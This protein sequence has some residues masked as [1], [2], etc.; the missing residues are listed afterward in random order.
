[1][2]TLESKIDILLNDTPFF[3][4][5]EFSDWEV[6]S[7][8]LYLHVKEKGKNWKEIRRMLSVTRRRMK[9]KQVARRIRARNSANFCVLS[10]RFAE[11]QQKYN[12]LENRV[13]EYQTLGE[14]YK[15][16]QYHCIDLEYQIE[17]YEDYNRLV[18]KIFQPDS[19]L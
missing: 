4:N 12:D 1:M 13:A 5:M 8:E 9:N 3:L 2:S 16:L 19:P 18:A 17:A 7:T 15:M 10:K 11:L 14:K 6:W